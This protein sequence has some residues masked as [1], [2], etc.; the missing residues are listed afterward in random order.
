MSIQESYNDWASGYDE[1]ENKTR[2]LEK[3]VALATLGG[4]F[5]D[6]I[7]ELGCG[8]GKNTAWLAEQSKRLVALDFSSE[9][10]RQAKDKI[11]NPVVHFKECD[12]NSDWPV[13][14]S[15]ANLIS[16]SLVLEH[17]ENLKP[18]FTK[19]YTKLASGGE[20][21]LCEY[22]P[23]KQYLGKGAKFQNEDQTIRLEVF[24]HHTSDFTCA[25]IEA[26]FSI[27]ELKEWFD[28]G[29]QSFPRLISFVFRKSD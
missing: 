23:A 6:H 19:A 15:L 18:I 13:E 5:F 26:G 17:I 11:K 1:M 22:H 24:I 20:F 28:P 21:Y 29:D 16:C 9:M 10:L 12:L 14:D 25:G 3:E 8:T 27:M 4:R 2:N 7:L